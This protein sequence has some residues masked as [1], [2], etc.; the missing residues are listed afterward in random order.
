MP[1]ANSGLKDIIDNLIRRYKYKYVCVNQDNIEI[2]NMINT[3][4]FCTLIKEEDTIK[5]HKKDILYVDYS[6]TDKRENCLKILHQVDN[7]KNYTFFAGKLNSLCN[8]MGAFL[9]YDEDHYKKIRKRTVHSSYVFSAN[10]PP[11]I[12]YHNIENLKHIFKQT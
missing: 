5:Y 6:K 3:N 8:G 10:L 12:I 2:I 9:S 11:Y 1:N 4:N 7:E